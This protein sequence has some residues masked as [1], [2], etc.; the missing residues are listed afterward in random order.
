MVFV[1]SSASRAVESDLV[2]GEQVQIVIPGNGSNTSGRGVNRPFAFGDNPETSN[3]PNRVVVE[4][5]EILLLKI[6]DRVSRF[7]CHH[8]NKGD[9][10]YDG[11]VG[12]GSLLGVAF[13]TAKQGRG[14]NETDALVHISIS[15]LIVSIRMRKAQ[16]LESREALSGHF[17]AS[18]ASQM[19]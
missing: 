2:S 11:V 18:L 6:Y 12:E 16:R 15:A 14:E 1:R 9:A 3:W 10:S 17:L 7:G 5:L 8:D 13:Q 19:L 4:H